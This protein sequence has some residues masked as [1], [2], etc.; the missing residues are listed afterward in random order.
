MRERE[1]EREK[2]KLATGESNIAKGFLEQLVQGSLLSR[3]Q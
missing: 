1:R 3:I 2:R